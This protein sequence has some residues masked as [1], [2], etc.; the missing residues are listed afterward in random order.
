MAQSDIERLLKKVAKGKPFPAFALVGA[1]SYLRELCRTKIL[2]AYIPKETRDW[3]VARF[4][5]ADD[6]DEIFRRAETLPILAPRQVLLVEETESLERLGD[7][8]RDAALDRLAAYLDDPAPFTILVFEAVALDQRRRLFKVLS[9]KAVVAKLEV[10]PKDAVTLAIGMGQELGVELK[11]SA[12]AL[13]VEILNGEP[14]RIRTELEKLSLYAGSRGR[15]AVADVEALVVSAKRYSIWQ[16]TDM[17]AGRKRDSALEF[18]DSLLGEGEQPAAIIGALAWMYRKLI[19]ARELSEHTNAFQAARLLG[20]RP[21]TA[22][23]ALRQSRRI[24]RGELLAGIGA[25]AEVDSVVKS[26]VAN[27]RAVM[28]FLVARLTATG[29]SSGA[30]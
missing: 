28:E 1:D 10:D 18:L 27:P 15:I 17:L 25:L 13:L 19:E 8:A 6:W 2:E 12:A 7:Q 24:P 21:E 30:V 14:A 22:E 9:E 11:H 4:S 26:A 29:A 20:M 23:L 5:A 3:G 16:L